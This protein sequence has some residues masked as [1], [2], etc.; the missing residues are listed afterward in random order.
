MRMTRQLEFVPKG[1][2]S[3]R[4]VEVS[5]G[6]PAPDADGNWWSLLEITGFDQPYSKRIPGA[7]AIQAVLSA[8]GLVP[9][10]VAAMAEGGRVTL[11]GSEDLGFRLVGA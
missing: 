5:I 6:V 11:D 1:A 3:A 7:D 8:A 2:T 9:H 4:T 10:L